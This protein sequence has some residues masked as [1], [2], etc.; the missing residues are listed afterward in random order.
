VGY[1]CA[2]PLPGACARRVREEG[3]DLSQAANASGLCRDP[4]IGEKGGLIGV[5]TGGR[6]TRPQYTVQSI[7]MALLSMNPRQYPCSPATVPAGINDPPKDAPPPGQGGRS[8]GDG[9]DRGGGGGGDQRLTAAHRRG[10]LWG[11]SAAA[12]AV[13]MFSLF[14]RR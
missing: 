12:A 6:V 2:W 7:Q 1:S 5:L 9:D 13:V 10:F 3:M 8:G 11:V 14:R 4:K